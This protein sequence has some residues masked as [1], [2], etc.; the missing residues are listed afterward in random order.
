MKKSILFLSLLVTFSFSFAAD[1][2]NIIKKHTPQRIPKPRK[3]SKALVG[4]AKETDEILF[5]RSKMRAA[6]VT[7]HADHVAKET[8]GPD[9]FILF[10]KHPNGSYEMFM[11]ETGD[12][13]IDEK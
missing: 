5:G 11:L 7:E 12:G 4:G 3:Y 1:G 10:S 2:S 8:Q 6:V 9:M 13:D